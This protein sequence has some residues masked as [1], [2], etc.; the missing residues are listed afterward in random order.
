MNQPRHEGADPPVPTRGVRSARVKITFVAAMVI[1][2]GAASGAYWAARSPDTTAIRPVAAQ[3]QL[4]P[5]STAGSSPFMT[6]VGTDQADLTPPAGTAGEF[7]GDAEGLYGEAGDEPACDTQTLLANLQ[8]DPT[9][10]AAWAEA[11]GVDTGDIPG[12]VNSLNPV[13]LR[14]DTAVTSYGYENGTFF[15]YPAVLQAGTSV[16]VTGYGEP[17][18]KCFSGNPLSEAQSS[19]QAS[20]VGPTWNYFQPAAITYVRPAPIVV[21]NYTMIDVRHGGSR[22]HSGKHWPGEE[23]GYCKKNPESD[24][25]KNN[26]GTS[27]PIGPGKPTP[28]EIKE[29]EELDKAATE[30]GQK[31]DQARKEATD[32]RVKANNVSAEAVEARSK[33]DQLKG[34]LDAKAQAYKEHT[35]VTIPRL[36]AALDAARAEADKNPTPENRAAFEQ[37]HRAHGDATVGTTLWLA[38]EMGQAQKDFD[39][40]AAS[41]Q[42]KAGQAKNAES[43][44]RSAEGV[45]TYAD[46]EA[47]KAQEAA[48]QG[49]VNKKRKGGEPAEGGANPQIGA[50]T[51]EDADEPVDPP[52]PP[53]GK[54]EQLAP[55]NVEPNDQQLNCRGV[56][57]PQPGCE[58]ATEPDTDAAK[59][60]K[61]AAEA[62]KA[63]AEKAAADAARV[64]EQEQVTGGSDE[65]PPEAPSPPDEN[66]ERSDTDGPAE[67]R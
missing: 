53:A 50:P 46:G 37:A 43:A 21:K 32:A 6:S 51:V 40:A 59:A 39:A 61:A 56:V 62:A 24:K 15:A 22:H 17:R 49:P 44:A 54:P 11:V 66:A 28:E 18:V 52:L 67:D 19:Q 20:Y 7:T 10:A 23:G 4:E 45:A 38:K 58:I 41:A 1:A 55:D 48:E 31:A 16:F 27:G 8:D 42:E 29:Q 9:K 60:E 63:A 36:K 47:K 33:A 5:V 35:E 57:G 2:V 14:S 26:G 30:A 65:Q 12:Y 13:V 3:V 34:A 25:C 64:A